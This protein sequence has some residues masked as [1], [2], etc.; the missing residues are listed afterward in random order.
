MNCLTPEAKQK[1]LGLAN[2]FHNE[3]EKEG[4]EYV[5]CG[6]SHLG[7]VREGGFIPWDYDL[8]CTIRVEQLAILFDIFLRV[9]ESQEYTLCTLYWLKN[10]FFKIILNSDPSIVLDIFVV[11]PDK[12]GVYR[13]LT[14][15]SR[16]RW[17]GWT[18]SS[19]DQFTK[20]RLVPF[21]DTQLY[22]PMNTDILFG[23]YGPKCLEER[24]FHRQIK[25]KKGE[26]NWLKREC[27]PVVDG[28]LIEE[29]KWISY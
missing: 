13:S 9:R 23:L 7:A 28:E 26:E 25:A 18:Y 5:L 22:V 14:E 24:V 16:T 29:N 21:E 1:F 6:G 20:R 27:I 3:S 19:I 11:A 12:Q 8:D 10:G 2:W 15:L 4:L 17:P